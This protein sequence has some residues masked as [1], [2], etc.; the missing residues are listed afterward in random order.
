[1]AW[2]AA[3]PTSSP[4]A[5]APLRWLATGARRDFRRCP[6][7]PKPACPTYKVATWYG[8]WAP[9]GSPR[10]ATTAMQAEMRKALNADDLKATWTAWAPI[11]PT[12]GA[13]TSA[14]FRLR[15]AFPKKLDGIAIETADTPQALFYTWR[16]LERG[17]AMLANLI[18]SLAL[19]P[20]SRIAVQTEKSVEA[21]MLYLAVLRAG[22]VYLPLNTAYQ[23]GEV[24][25]SSATPNRPWWCAAAA[26]PAGSAIVRA[27][28]VRHVFTLDDD[29]T[30][31]LLDAPPARATGTRRWCARPMIWRPSCTPAAPPD[32]ARA[33]C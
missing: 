5:C 6:P 8:I 1:M 28:G 14:A 18:G 24:S 17:T 3:R 23:A 10:E 11:R 12:C 19:P 9:K 33:P 15:A 27:A 25:T 31:S 7:P 30:G 21:L 22:H 13:R 26:T 16:D 20:E 29:R 32:A 2:A 4:A